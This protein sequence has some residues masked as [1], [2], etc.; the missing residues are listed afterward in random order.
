[1]K[2]NLIGERD[3]RKIYADF[4][5]DDHNMLISQVKGMV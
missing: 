3:C 5:L 4:Y 1:M 2:A